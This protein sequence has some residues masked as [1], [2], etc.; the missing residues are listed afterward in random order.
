[1]RSI[2]KF[3]A[4]LVMT[5]FAAFA[6]AQTPV[7]MVLSVVGDVTLE[8]LGQPVK[9][10]AFSR[11]LSGDRVKLGREAGVSF[12]YPRS[13][14]QENWAGTGILLAGDSESVVVTGKP[15]VEIKQLPTRIAQQMARTPIS[16]TSGKAGMVRMRA[17]PMSESLA[18]LEQQVDKLR[19]ESTPGDRSP[20]VFRLAGLNDLGMIDLLRE[21]L[22]KLEKANPN[23]ASVKALVKAYARVV[24][25]EKSGVR[26]VV[27]KQAQ[28]TRK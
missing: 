8:V 13:G 17:I 25:V 11:L 16:D 3:L 24:N 9:V 18:D 22:L 12:I 4:G 10:E 23:D 20:D 28:R 5:L 27:S 6:Q 15:A 2:L 7:A 14:R 1:M 21:E 19:A 26:R